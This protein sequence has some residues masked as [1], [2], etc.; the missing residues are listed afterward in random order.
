[1]DPCVGRGGA[2]HLPPEL[3]EHITRTRVTTI[4]QIIDLTSTS[5]FAQGWKS[6]IEL[7]FPK[8]WHEDWHNYTLALSKSHVRITQGE[9]ELIWQHVSHGHYTP[10]DGYLYIFSNSRPLNTTWWWQCL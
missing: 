3:I 5:I 6:A 9:D 10:K 7:G 8:Q 2:H 4:D 1:M